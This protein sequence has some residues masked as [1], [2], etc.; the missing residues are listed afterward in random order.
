MRPPAWGRAQG[1]AWS[2]DGKAIKLESAFDPLRTLPLAAYRPSV[3]LIWFTLVV[4]A[5]ACWWL[6][7]WGRLAVLF[8]A[9]GFAVWLFVSDV[10]GRWINLRDFTEQG[11]GADTLEVGVMI[12]V[13]LALSVG[14]GVKAFRVKG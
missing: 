2:G 1:R 3:K 13:P 14:C 11:L 12:F 8:F 9:L 7:M 4:L 6:K 10:A 5:L